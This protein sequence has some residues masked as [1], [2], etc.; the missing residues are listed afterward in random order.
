MAAGWYRPPASRPERGSGAGGRGPREDRGDSG[1][2][3]SRASLRGSVRAGDL[4]LQ[5]LA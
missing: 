2:R 4:K 5:R 1:T 3:P